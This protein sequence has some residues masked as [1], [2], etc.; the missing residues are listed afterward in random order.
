MQCSE[1]CT[2]SCEMSFTT[3]FATQHTLSQYWDFILTSTHTETLNPHMTERTHTP[4]LYLK[5]AY[6][7]SLLSDNLIIWKR[8]CLQGSQHHT[9]VYYFCPL[10]RNIN[11]QRFISICDCVK[12]LDVWSISYR[13]IS[14]HRYDAYHDIIMKFSSKTITLHFK[15]DFLKIICRKFGLLPQKINTK[16][17]ERFFF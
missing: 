16:K 9:H 5:G 8:P 15:T 1:N 7:G 3:S 2:R 11:V 4:A 17:Q 14:S 10:V 13:D 6:L 12:L